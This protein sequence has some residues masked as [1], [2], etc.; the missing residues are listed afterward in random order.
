MHAR[1]RALSGL[2]AACAPAQRA[3]LERTIADLDRRIAALTTDRIQP[4]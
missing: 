1:G 4:R 2:Q 3:S